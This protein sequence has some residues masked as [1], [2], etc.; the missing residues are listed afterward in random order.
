MPDRTRRG[1]LRAAGTTAAL[2]TMPPAIARAL[3]IPAARR[4]GTLEDVQHI[5]VLTQENRSFDHYFGGFNGVRGF[6]DRFPI[7][8][9]DRVGRTGKTVWHQPNAVAGAAPAA[10]TPFRLDTGERFALMRASGTPHEWVDAQNAWD[11]G[12]MNAWP[13]SKHNHAMGH[14]AQA[15]LPFQWALAD[16]FTLCDAYH[17]AAQTGTNTNRLFLFTGTNDPLGRGNGPATHNDYDWFDR[18]HGD[19]GY[20]WTTYPERLDAAGI[21]WQVYQD[22]ADNYT[23]NPLAGFQRFRAAWFGRPGHAETLRRRGVSTRR[24]DLLKADV[25]AGRL[26]SVAW[27]VAPAA[28][29]EHPGP[30]SPAQ[31]ADYTARVLDALTADPAVWARTVLL[32]NFDEND[33]FFDHVPPPAPPSYEAWHADPALARRAGA[34]TIDTRGEYHEILRPHAGR[35][36]DPAEQALLHRP[37][38]MGPRVPLYVVSPWSRGG[39]VDSQVFDHTSVIRFME[40]RF[41][42]AEPNISAWRRAVAGDLTSAF[43]FADPDDRA[44]F[45]SLPATLAPARRALAL[46]EQA[47]PDVPRQPALPVQAGGVRPSRALPYA[48]HTDAEVVPGAGVRLHLGNTG[49]QAAVFHVYDRHRLEAIPRRYTVGPG[50]SLSDHW[51]AAAGGA[52]DLWVLGPNGFH[53]HFTGSVRQALAAW[54]DVEVR[55]DGATGELVLRLMNKGE[56]PCTMRLVANAYGTPGASHL[57]APRTEQTLRRPLQASGHWYDCSVQVAGLAGFSRRFAG[58]VETGRA[59]VSDPA[60]SGR[61]TGEQW[62]AG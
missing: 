13:L 62:R 44:F 59:S 36:R 41:G 5:V 53:S 43:N 57:L 45:A 55:G 58:R 32:L 10:L 50:R 9:A 51:P 52:Y 22:M 46:A 61:A 2:A 17:C 24:L 14:Y 16:A 33:G 31:G 42:V 28:D 19:G 54:P 25:L 29:C 4:S 37:Y 18:D 7:P 1:L 21:G 60:M 27:I 11:H 23:D 26:P 6:A 48:L 56:A 35:D 49:A 15:D 34:S 40:R 30:S 3:A 20:S 39:W 12:R 47:L 8:V 38:G